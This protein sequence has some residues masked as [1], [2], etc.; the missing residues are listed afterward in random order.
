MTTIVHFT[1]FYFMHIRGII[2]RIAQATDNLPRWRVYWDFLLIIK[3]NLSCDNTKLI[4]YH[5]HSVNNVL[6]MKEVHLLE[7]LFYDGFKALTNMARQK[8]NKHQE[9]M[10]CFPTNK[11]ESVTFY[12]VPK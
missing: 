6:S 11:E 5:A 3:Q 8:K 1:K 2:H 7:I 9:D 10:Y 4:A 12:P